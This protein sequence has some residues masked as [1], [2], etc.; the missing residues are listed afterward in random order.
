[1]W[2]WFLLFRVRVVFFATFPE[3]FMSRPRQT[4]KPFRKDLKNAAII[5]SFLFI[6]YIRISNHLQMT[7]ISFVHV[8][9]LWMCCL[10]CSRNDGTLTGQWLVCRPTFNTPLTSAPQ[11]LMVQAARFVLNCIAEA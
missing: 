10:L 11:T 8:T 9:A 3:R 2:A 1:L 4:T 7:C 5:G 6:L